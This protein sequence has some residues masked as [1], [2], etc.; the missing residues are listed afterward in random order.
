MNIPKTSWWPP[1]EEKIELLEIVLPSFMPTNTTYQG[2]ITLKNIGQSIWGESKKTFSLNEPKNNSIYISNLEIPPKTFVYPKQTITLQF[3]ISTSS[4]S[5]DFHF[6]WENLPIQKIKVLPSSV[7][8]KAKYNL[9]EKI[10][11]KL[12]NTLASLKI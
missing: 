1:Q 4:Q 11:I 7:I 12:K 6:N 3:Q 9:W 8:S 10:I 2:K 5:G